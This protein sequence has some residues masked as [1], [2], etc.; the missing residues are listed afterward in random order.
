MLSTFPELVT[1]YLTHLQNRPS[2]SRTVRLASQWICQLTEIPTRQQILDRHRTKGAI[3]RQQANKEL[4]LLRTIIRWGIYEEHWTGS[5]PTDGIRPWKCARRRRVLRFREMQLLLHAFDFARTH[6]EQRDRALFGLM[7]FTGCRPGEART[8]KRSD[9][10]PYGEMGCWTKWTTKTG[11]SQ[12]VPVPSCVMRWLHALP[13]DDSIYYFGGLDRYALSDAAV[14]KQWAKWRTAYQLDGVWTY[15]F[16][17]TL[18]TYLQSEL[19]QSDSMVQAILNHYDSRAL[20]HYVHHPFDS[21]ARTIQAY[22]EWLLTLKGDHHAIPH[23]VVPVSIHPLQP[24][25]PERTARA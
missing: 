25:V 5:N 19:Q 13:S 24:G 3:A 22:A 16:R 7:I 10:T 2:H 21:L 23:S 12:E 11:E 18:A 6:T 14:R 15:D 4:K 1:A 9:I 8:V 17:R 20:G